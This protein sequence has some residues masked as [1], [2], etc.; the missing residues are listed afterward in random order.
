M[1]LLPAA[2]ERLLHELTRLPGIGRRGAERIALHLLEAPPEQAGQ[3]AEALAALRREVRPCGLCGNWAEGE[4][5]AICADPRRA[6]GQLCVVERAVDIWAFEAAEAY[7]GRYHVLGGTLSPLAG[8]TADDLRIT[9]LEDRLGPEGISEVILATNASVD[10]DATAHYLSQRLSE[11]GL[12]T[13][14]I[15]Q[16]VPLGGHLDY[17]DPGTLRLALQ[18]RRPLG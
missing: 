9:E 13:T 6:T 14:R 2:L 18:G 8:V 12:R 17:A 11:R 4:R 16:G 15:A 10:G 3:L 7:Q 1:A 5:C